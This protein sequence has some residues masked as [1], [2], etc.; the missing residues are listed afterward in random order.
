MNN[1]VYY[2]P[3]FKND[4]TLITPKGV[5]LWSYYVYS[6]FENAKKDFPDRN[7]IAYSGNDIESPYFIDSYPFAEIQ[8]VKR[9][10]DNKVFEINEPVE[11]GGLFQGV[12]IGFEKF[13]DDFRVAVDDGSYDNRNE[14]IE[15]TYYS[16]AELD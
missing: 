16:I 15:G 4:D 1:N 9:V 5:E 11:I 8:Q 14:E 7:I 6:N 12:I 2:Q 13:K 3:D 10:L